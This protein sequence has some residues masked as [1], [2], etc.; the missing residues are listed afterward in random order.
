[1][2]KSM[3]FSVALLVC[4]LGASAAGP[5]RTTIAVWDFDNNSFLDIAASDCLT[6]ALPEML[7]SQLSSVPSLEVVE[8]IQIREI[9]EEQKIGSSDLADE[10]AKLKL[11][12]IIGAKKM[13]FG[14]FMVIGDDVRVDVRLANTETSEVEF[15]EKFEGSI[16]ELIPSMQGIATQLVDLFGKKSGDKSLGGDL[17]EWKE[18]EVGLSLIDEGKYEEALAQFQ[19]V[20]EKNP[21]FYA[22][23]KQVMLIIDLM[24]RQ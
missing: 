19:A 18:Y 1:M 7:M 12:N 6:K 9:L 15:A 13:I 2:F 21:K 10:D 17:G 22:A 16:T 14:T 11:G 3:I 8:R 24:A 5:N 4:S 20:L 23:E